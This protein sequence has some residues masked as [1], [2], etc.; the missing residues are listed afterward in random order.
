M[1]EG[2]VWCSVVFYGVVRCGV[3]RCGVV[4]CGVGVGL[5]VGVRVVWVWV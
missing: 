3:V 2:A 5:S 1:I 4:W